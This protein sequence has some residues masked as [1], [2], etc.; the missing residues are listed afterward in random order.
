MDEERE[1]RGRTI[2]TYNLVSIVPRVRKLC[3]RKGI[4]PVDPTKSDRVV[5]CAECYSPTANLNV[6]ELYK[7]F[8]GPILAFWRID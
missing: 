6:L 7:P 1:H 4:P 3:V 5:K 8:S 2:E